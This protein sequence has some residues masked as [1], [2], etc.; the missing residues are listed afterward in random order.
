MFQYVYQRKDT[1]L[2]ITPQISHRW[3]MR[4]K[5]FCIE[6]CRSQVLFRQQFLQRIKQLSPPPA[7]TWIEL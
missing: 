5:G 3:R 6:I 4:I 2:T 1:N 7:L